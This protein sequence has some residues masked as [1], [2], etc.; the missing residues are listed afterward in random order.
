MS[1]NATYRTFTTGDTA[2]T[3]TALATLAGPL[4]AEQAE[5]ARIA[6]DALAPNTRRAYR[7]ALASVADWHGA[8]VPTDATMAR[9]L[10]ERFGAGASPATLKLAV[11]AVR[12]MARKTGR[13]SPTG[14]RTR[15]TLKRLSEDGTDRGRGQASPLTY[16]E[17]VRIVTL[18][19]PIDGAIVACLFMAGLR[20]SEVAALEWRDLEDGADGIRITV[21]TSKTNRDGGES[22]VRYVKNGFAQAL[23]SIRPANAAPQASVFGGRDARTIAR[24]FQRAART[25]GIERKLSAHSGRIGL[26][27]EL[28]ARGASEQEVMIA[29]HWKTSRMVAHY[30]AGARAE[31]GAVSKYF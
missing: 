24:R 3:T 11:A 28:T 15:D 2:M 19:K 16:D 4:S 5:T 13:P 31:R 29:G 18:A 14:E 1:D 23:R 21:R 12:W 27:S 22:D 25:A 8:E 10:A 20:R 26:A 30:S 6:L 17:A 9:Y 7:I